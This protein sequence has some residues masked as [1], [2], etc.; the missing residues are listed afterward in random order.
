MNSGEE[1]LNSVLGVHDDVNKIIFTRLLAFKKFYEIEEYFTVEDEGIEF[2]GK[3]IK[4]RQNPNKSKIKLM[5]DS[6]KRHLIW[7]Q[8][9]KS[10]IELQKLS[11][12]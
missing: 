5:S 11:S 4:R 8:Q 10:A 2:P 1:D 3:K 6:E 7:K 12:I 9:C